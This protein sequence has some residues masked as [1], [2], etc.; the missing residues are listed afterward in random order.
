MSHPVTCTCAACGGSTEFLDFGY[1]L[2]DCIW[3][4]PPAERGQQGQSFAELGARR[5][6]RCLFPIR[7]EDARE[8][9][10]GPWI[11]VEA[12][13]FREIRE[14]WDDPRYA[15]L[16]FTGRIA[17]AMPPWRE[18][19]AN[20]EVELAVRDQNVRPFVVASSTPWI[21]ELLDCGWTMAEYRAAAKELLP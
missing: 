10:Y 4:L 5:F 11:E 17:N 3:A 18:R 7:L 15:T 14:I 6:V 20:I 13:T 16:R 21:Q 1:Q 19:I 8:F 12:G 2:P 9:R